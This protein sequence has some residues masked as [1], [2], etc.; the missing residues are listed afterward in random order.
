MTDKL[1]PLEKPSL[2]GMSEEK[3]RE[4]LVNTAVTFAD[5]PL[6]ELISLMYKIDAEVIF[7]EVSKDVGTVRATVQSRSPD[8][9]NAGDYEFS[10]GVVDHDYMLDLGVL[11][12]NP[13][14]KEHMIFLIKCV[15]VLYTAL[16]VYINH[17]ANINKVEPFEHDMAIDHNTTIYFKKEFPRRIGIIKRKLPPR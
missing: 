11:H 17:W 8:D 16:K 3:K 9:P 12:G 7:P 5:R 14:I 1:Q 4:H 15:Q 13:K 10:L 6:K 2:D